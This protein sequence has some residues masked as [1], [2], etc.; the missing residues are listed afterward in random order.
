MNK[1]WNRLSSPLSAHSLHSFERKQGCESS[2]GSRNGDQ[3]SVITAQ[4]HCQRVSLLVISN[5]TKTSPEKQR[6]HDCP[7]NSTV[8]TMA[9]GQRRSA[10]HKFPSIVLSRT[11]FNACCSQKKKKKA[12][13][14]WNIRITSGSAVFWNV[15]GSLVLSTEV[16]QLCNCRA[17]SAASAVS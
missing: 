8:F 17:N 13:L 4:L 5:Q 6:R 15:L 10:I 2:C 3:R 14:H 11:S 9:P 16:L 7:H 12:T 1:S